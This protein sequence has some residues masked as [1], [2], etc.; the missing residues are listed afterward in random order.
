MSDP[1]TQLLSLAR[2]GNGGTVPLYGQSL[3]T[4]GYYVGGKR[5]TLVMDRDQ[6]NDRSQH[7][8]VAL[9]LAAFVTFADSPYV[10]AWECEGKIYFDATEWYEDLAQATA[11]GNSRGEI[12]IW[13]VQHSSEITL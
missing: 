5:E 8:A 2:H 12:A 6:V 7:R 9:S 10:G 13:D 3:P 11:V 4:T 1:A